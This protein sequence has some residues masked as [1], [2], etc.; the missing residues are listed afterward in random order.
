LWQSFKDEYS[1]TD[2]TKVFKTNKRLAGRFD[3]A[4]SDYIFGEYS[5]DERKHNASSFSVDIN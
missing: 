2:K 4:I 5:V 3:D 1:E